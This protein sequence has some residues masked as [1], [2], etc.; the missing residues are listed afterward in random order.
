MNLSFMKYLIISILIIL[1]MN[2]IAQEVIRLYPG[3]I[4]NSKPS[5]DLEYSEINDDNILLISKISRPTLTAYFPAPGK[6]NCDAIIICPGGGYSI[7]AAGHEGAD[8]AKKLNELGITAFVLKYRIPDSSWMIN[9]E[10]GPLQDAQRAIQVVR[11]NATR[12]KI[13]KNSIGIL[14]FSAGGHLASTAAT[15]FNKAYIPNRKRISLRPDFL[16]LV[17]P[18]ITMTDT[19]QHISSKKICLAKPQQ[20]KNSESFQMNYKLLRKHHLH[21]WYMQKMIL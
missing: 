4:P 8:V 17:Y 16:V 6:S 5:P 19:A 13:S 21:S 11:E 18:V 12:W 2:S 3:A 15:H 1:T 14:G 20:L 10:T 9:P 7:V